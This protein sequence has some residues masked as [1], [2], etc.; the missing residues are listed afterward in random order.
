[1]KRLS[2]ISLT[3][4]LV[5]GATMLFCINLPE[6]PAGNPKYADITL[7]IDN[8][9]LHRG[10]APQIG[11]AV[12]FT[13]HFQ[14]VT[15]R[16]SCN[17]FDTS[18]ST[19]SLEEYDTLY[20]SPLFDIT[21]PCTV[22]VNAQFKDNGL[23]D[24]CDTLSLYIFPD[25]TGIYFSTKQAS[26]KTVTGKNDTLLF[27]TGAASGTVLPP[28]YTITAV[29][30]EG[31]T[32][33]PH[34]SQKM[35]TI[36]IITLASVADSFTVKVLA[37]ALYGG[38]LVKDSVFTGLRVLSAKTLLP[39]TI[40]I[41]DP[42]YIGTTDTLI[43]TLDNNNISEKLS[44]K[45]TA[46]A[47]HD[48]AIFAVLA[49]GTDSL[50]IAVTPVQVCTTK[51]G[52]IISNST[53]SDTTW[54]PVI[55]R[56]IDTT[57]DTTIIDTTSNTDSTFWNKKEISIDATE[58]TSLKHDLRQYFIKPVAGSV[59]F[60]ADPGTIEDTILKWTPPY[61]SKDTVPVT[62]SATNDTIV[63]QL[64]CTLLITPSDT[65]RPEL[66]LIDTSLNGKKVSSP[67]I[68]VQAI[69]KDSEAGID[70]VIIT[71]GTVT[72]PAALQQD[73]TY[74]GVVSGLQN[75]IPTEITITAVDKSMKKNTTALKFTV[76]FDST[77]DGVAPAITTPLPA[78][79]KVT[80]GE[81]LSLNVVASGSPA[82]T[83]Q[84]YKGNEV[85]ENQISPE[86]SK[87][88]VTA[89]D[90]GLYHVVVSNGIGTPVISTKTAVSIRFKAKITQQPVAASIKEGGNGSF[91]VKARG[92]APLTYQWY[93]NGEL[94][95]GAA[96]SKYSFTNADT[97]DNGKRFTCVVSNA[98]SK[99][100]SKAGILTVTKK[101]VYQVS[102]DVDGG[103]PTI[104]TETVR[105]G[106]KIQEPPTKP[107][108]AGFTF[109]G[110][111]SSQ[112]AATL[113]SFTTTSITSDI[114][115]YAKWDPI[116]Y[117]VT[118]DAG[119]GTSIPAKTVYYDYCVIQPTN[120]TKNGVIF[121]KWYSDTGCTKEWIFNGGS[122][123]CSK[124]VSDTTLYAKWVVMD[125][126]GNIYDTVR[127]GN[128]TWLAQNLRTTRYRDGMA[129]QLIN[130]SAT[131]AGWTTDA[132]CWP[133]DNID[134][135][136]VYGALYNWH[137]F[138]YR[139]NIAPEGWHLP[140]LAEWD[141]LRQYLVTHGY[142]WDGTIG[143]GI[144]AATNLIL[145]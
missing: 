115:I 6:S 142:N 106:E 74:S 126:D 107:I 118:F 22:F 132:Y 95:T 32:I 111:Y 15:L 62:I 42:I 8:V 124:I 2:L 50:R 90:S 145:Q 12:Y 136:K 43:F 81:T 137:T 7:S 63:S 19:G 130:D 93:K 100:T 117:T 5:V 57:I 138:E 72:T 23:R 37:S 54:Y 21:G 88:N 134:S 143:D 79:V 125:R 40:V 87:S 123:S 61:G 44:I 28:E 69:A 86:F 68:T 52:V 16:T 113:F 114:M 25:E 35:D 14:T 53:H 18:F 105:E 135:G 128:Q 76:T 4:S 56:V 59:T 84:W 45:H 112:T 98:F 103:S 70:S 30:S 29:P 47:P 120:P 83:Y 27:V 110:W 36:R 3:L 31:I 127:I 17:V 104:A 139:S 9:M 65:T 41:P 48:S 144:S 89:D 141:I 140:S 60:S 71:C 119:G 49:S 51:I 80:E 26:I 121:Y 133:D 34:Y 24:K 39:S 116:K 10:D 129:I 66:S 11:V 99:D 77:A 97:T 108:K 92:E 46:L 33:T 96:S 131:W 82:P 85:L 20:F 122:G 58:G 91:T 13:Q 75:E 55:F 67:Q 102:F 101:P 78:T 64:K 94:I 109:A 38:S 1:M 73:S